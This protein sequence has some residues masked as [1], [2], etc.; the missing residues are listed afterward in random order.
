MG[1]TNRSIEE[2]NNA[3]VTVA[4]LITKKKRISRMSIADRQRESIVKCLHG[5]TRNCI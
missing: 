2:D 1:L 5:G 3:N 4:L